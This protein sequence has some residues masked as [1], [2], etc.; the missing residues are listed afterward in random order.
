MAF[1]TQKQNK[2]TNDEKANHRKRNNQETH[3]APINAPNKVPTL[4]RLTINPLLTSLNSQVLACDIE[5]ADE[6]PLVLAKRSLK[7]SMRRMSDIW[8]VS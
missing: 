8:P 7:S 2:E 1:S 3:G 5:T 4:K 6:V